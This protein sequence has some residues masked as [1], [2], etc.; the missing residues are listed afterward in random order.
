MNKIKAFIE[1][2][3]ENQ[4]LVGQ[5]LK[6]ILLFA[7]LSGSGTKLAVA[8]SEV[9]KYCSTHDVSDKFVEDLS[10]AV[11]PHVAMIKKVIDYE[12]SIHYVKP[13]SL[14][15]RFSAAQNNK[16]QKNQNS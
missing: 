14:M 8:Y 12:S 10:D 9:W 11:A 15:G 3:N 1:A 2:N 4:E 6:A 16:F 7:Y 5:A 13:G